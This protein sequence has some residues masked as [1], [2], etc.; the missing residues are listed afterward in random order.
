M[1]KKPAKYAVFTVD[2]ESFGDTECVSN[3]G[4]EVQQ[5]MLDGLDEYIRILDKYGIKATMFS[6][7]RTAL[8]AKERIA[9]HIANGHSLALHS[10]DHSVPCRLSNEKFREETALAQKLLSEAF[11][12]EVTG[13]RA[14]CFGMDN[15]KLEIL[16]ELGFLYDSSRMNFTPA[17]HCVGVDMQNF[18]EVRKGIFRSGTFY[19]FELIC[20]RIFGRIFPISGGGYVRMC[21]WGLMR[22]TIADYIRKNNYYVFYLHPFELSRQR[23]PKIPGLKFYDRFYLNYGIRSFPRRVER[24]IKLLKK[25]GYEFVT[26]EDLATRIDKE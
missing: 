10:M 24:I 16:K 9:P 2:V 12:A 23:M 14:P 1:M 15:D 3:T 20:N 7:C 18:D 19:E 25:N 26:F 21:N 4:V 13:Y 11:G 6:V 8:A 22:A 17:R 5:D